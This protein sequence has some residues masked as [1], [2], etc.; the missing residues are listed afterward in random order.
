M[1]TITLKE[2]RNT[3]GKV[4]KLVASGKVVRVTRRGKPLFDITPV[5]QQS[6]LA[7]F[8]K[9]LD[10]AAEGAPEVS[11]EDMMAGLRESRE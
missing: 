4:T 11:L 1:P 3:P 8:F 2:L 10:A 9:K 5:T 6:G 7:A